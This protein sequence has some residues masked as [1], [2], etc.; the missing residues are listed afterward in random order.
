MSELMFIWIDFGVQTIFTNLLSIFWR[1][2][3]Y[4]TYLQTDVIIDN[5]IKIEQRLFRFFSI[6]C[7]TMCRR[8]IRIAIENDSLWSVLHP[9]RAT[10]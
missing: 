2:I 1:I 6:I 10:V 3:V 8:T 9:S 4:I 7:R 5:K